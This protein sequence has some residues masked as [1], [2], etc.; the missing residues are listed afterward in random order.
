M[1]SPE[2]LSSL[3]DE[4]VFNNLNSSN[5]TKL[6]HLNTRK[7]LSM[8]STNLS[9][10]VSTNGMMNGNSSSANS[11]S[12]SS[13]S[14][15]S[16]SSGYES[17]MRKQLE[18]NDQFNL[19]HIFHPLLAESIYETSTKLLLMAIKWTKSLPTFIGLNCNDQVNKKV[20][21]KN[22]LIN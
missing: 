17:S 15:T 14:V 19:D 10:F 13:S 21:I 20:Q 4:N 8:T 22:D 7:S 3:I 16:F 1:E 18:N 6:D 9:N 5:S 11:A 2:H 12:S